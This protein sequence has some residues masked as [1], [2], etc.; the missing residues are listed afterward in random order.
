MV[1]ETIVVGEGRDEGGLDRG[2]LADDVKRQGRGARVEE[3]RDEDVGGAVVRDAGRRGGEEEEPSVG[4]VGAAG[5]AESVDD[6][7][8][9]E[10]VGAVTAEAEA[11][12]EAEGLVDV[13]IDGA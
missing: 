6:A 10:G 7:G 9:V 4:L 5:V 1:D 3:A 2:Q 13:A 8:E 12:E 11:I